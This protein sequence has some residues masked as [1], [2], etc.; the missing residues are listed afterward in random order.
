MR[1]EGRRRASAHV[2]LSSSTR[3]LPRFAETPEKEIQTM[4]LTVFYHIN[5]RGHG[6]CAFHIGL[7]RAD[8]ALQKLR[9]KECSRTFTPHEG[10]QCARCLA[11]NEWSD[12]DD[13]S[14]VCA[15]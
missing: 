9:A 7:A 8:E 3:V 5:P 11:M 2:N 12:S 14:N 6:C 10:W 1:Q 4:L 13:D 15:I